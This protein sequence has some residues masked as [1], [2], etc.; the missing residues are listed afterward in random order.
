MTKPA[1]KRNKNAEL[2]DKE[3][4]LPRAD[5]EY[6]PWLD[7]LNQ[8]LRSR[9]ISRGMALLDRTEPLWG[10][11]R[12]S[13]WSDSHLLL[14]L[15]QWVD[16]GYRDA[17]FLRRMLDLLSPENRLR[18]PVRDYVQ[19][20][21]A[22]AFYAFAVDDADETI[23]T[24]EVVLRLDDELL[25][26]QAKTLAHLWKGRAHRKK[27]DYENAFTHVLAARDLASTL[28]E[29]ATI[30]AVI[31]V[32][33]GWLVFQR[34]DVSGALQIFDEAEQV[35]R[36]TDHWIALGNIESAR[37][38]IIRRKGDYVASL[39]H[40]HRSVEF[41]QAHH[42]QHP[43]LARAVTNLAFVK[44]LLALQLKRHIDSIASR[45]EQSQGDRNSQ[46]ASLRPLHKQLQELYRSA[47][48]DLERA[49]SICILHEHHNALAAALLNAG[50]L[51]LDVGDLELAKREATEAF[52][53][54]DKTNS[55]VLKARAKILSGLIENARLE[56]RLGHPEDAPA[57]ARLARQH[58]MDALALAMTTE[59]TRLLVNAHLAL[60]EVAT[61][62]FFSDYDLARRCVDSASALIGADEADYVVDELTALR[63]KLLHVVGIDDTLR[64]WSQ[65][66][67]AGKSL[68]DVMNEFAQLVVTQVWLREGR[69]ISRV[70]KQLSTSP[71]KVR[72]LIRHAG[73]DAEGGANNRK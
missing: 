45:R 13:G 72:R 55:A 65:G 30:I 61:N 28:P 10:S 70:A 38:R 51:H 6:Q 44:R 15:A 58:C 23:R 67:V 69:R 31:Q 29:S 20:R 37:G 1:T 47:V 4:L 8:M 56:E 57:F 66:T 3:A 9:Q 26:A 54:G 63:A 50:Q 19:L 27:A 2:P 60:G 14:T 17:A 49:K 64:A 62:S 22:E 39:A 16:V 18:L 71:K 11:L 40:F 42:P 52:A 59:N 5:A 34:G 12:L 53:I 48:Q 25:N 7:Q 33:Q 43:N 32:Q 21:M 36:G 73:L 41:Y 46:T 68:Q 24:L 35:L